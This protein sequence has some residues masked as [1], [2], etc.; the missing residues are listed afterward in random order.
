MEKRGQ[1]GW[2]GEG[3]GGEERGERGGR[4]EE[5]GD[6]I[7]DMNE[8]AHWRP[9][10]DLDGGIPHILIDANARQVEVHVCEV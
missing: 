6:Y 5:G 1:E 8:S 7:F 2:G 4:E 3:R 9:G 10:I